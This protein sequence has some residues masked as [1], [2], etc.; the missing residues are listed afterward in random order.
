M[1]GTEYELFAKICKQ[2]NA[3]IKDFTHKGHCIKCGECCSNT[4][5]LS[6]SEI[7]TIRAYITEHKIEA[8]NHANNVKAA[9]KV[10]DAVCPFLGLDKRCAIYE[11]RPLICR[12]FKCNRPVP[13]YK[14][15]KL[16]G[17][18]DRQIKNV[19]AVF[20]GENEKRKNS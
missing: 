4:I 17:K 11:V 5:P 16:M 7:E 1:P 9:G 13:P 6:Q 2:L 19:R 15:I 10:I 18:E 14:H 8:V 3:G 12:L 20:F